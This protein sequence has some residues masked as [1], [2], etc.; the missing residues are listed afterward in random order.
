MAESLTQWAGPHRH[1]SLVA[2]HFDEV[3]RRHQRWV[4]WRTRWAH[5]VSCRALPELLPQDA[6]TCLFAPGRFMLQI[7]DPVRF[8]GTVSRDPAAVLRIQERI[9][10][11]LQRS[12]EAFPVT[13]LG[14]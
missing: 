3:S 6:P 7:V 4:N 1:L 8:R 9:D 5:V 12:E 11:I 14:L 2:L 13:T 10:A